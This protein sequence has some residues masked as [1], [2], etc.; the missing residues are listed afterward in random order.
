[1]RALRE[2]VL[3]RNIF[4]WAIEVLD[5]TLSLTLQTPAAEASNTQ[6]K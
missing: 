1:M 6:G 5:T 4:D 2:A 3:R